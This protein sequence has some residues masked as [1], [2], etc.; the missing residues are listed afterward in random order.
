MCL[1][2]ISVHSFAG[3]AL[4]HPATEQRVDGGPHAAPATLGILQPHDVGSG[5]GHV[6]VAVA[7]R[8]GLDILRVTCRDMGRDMANG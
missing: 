5:A 3:L 1:Q 7:G 2:K 6:L 4:Q 8:C